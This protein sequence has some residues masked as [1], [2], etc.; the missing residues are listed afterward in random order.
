MR[1]SHAV[2]TIPWQNKQGLTLPSVSDSM[3]LWRFHWGMP[4][5]TQPCQEN[6]S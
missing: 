4:R 1:G 3:L 5:R 6:L 2:W